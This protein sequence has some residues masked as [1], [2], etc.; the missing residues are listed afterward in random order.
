MSF[1][2]LRIKKWMKYLN[3]SLT[4]LFCVLA[5]LCVMQPAQ[6][7]GTLALSD[8][9]PLLIQSEDLNREVKLI[10]QKTG[11][12]P[13]SIVC[14]GIRLGRHFGPLGAARIAP[15]ECSFPNDKFLVIEATNWIKLPNGT[16][17]NAEELVD[18]LSENKPLAE[19]STLQMNLQSW[20]WK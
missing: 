11:Q 3:L 16:L 5:T 9:E 15:F 17:I 8:L 6:S 10:L 14:I 2:T 7:G 19:G 1:S 12:T 4:S 20:Q 18:Q 13:D